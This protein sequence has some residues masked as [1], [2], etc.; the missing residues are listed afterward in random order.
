[1]AEKGISEADA[2]KPEIRDYYETEKLALEKLV[3]EGHLK[4]L[5]TMEADVYVL[6]IGKDDFP[7]ALS[8]TNKN[9]VIRVGDEVHFKRDAHED[10]ITIHDLKIGE[11]GEIGF[12]NPKIENGAFTIEHAIVNKS[13]WDRLAQ[14]NMKGSASIVK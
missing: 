12:H 3:F 10:D 6:P 13:A 5:Q 14:I 1:M 7:V 8:L 4:K 2:F 11:N 9:M